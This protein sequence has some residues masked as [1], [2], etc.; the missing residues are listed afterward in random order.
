VH[1]HG[2]RAHAVPVLAVLTV[3]ALLQSTPK[4]AN[5]AAHVLPRTAGSAGAEPGGAYALINLGS[6][7][8]PC[9]A[10]SGDELILVSI[11]AQRVWMCKASTQVYS[12]LVTTGAETGGDA[13]PVGTWQIQSKQT[14]RYLVGPGYRY[15]VHWWMPFN[16]DFGFHDA[17]WQTMPYGSPGYT[18]NGSHGCVHL[19]E[20]AMRWLYGWAGVGTRVTIQA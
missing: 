5:S 16:G 18:D 20:A 3:L 17:P 15:F 6:D 8:T 19:P 4:H 11:T 9:T 10:N 13:T 12:T 1:R 2:W 7:A 14:D